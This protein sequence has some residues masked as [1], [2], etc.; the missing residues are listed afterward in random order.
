MFLALAYVLRSLFKRLGFERAELVAVLQVP[1]V[2]NQPAFTLP[3]A[4][5]FA[6]LTELGHFS[7]PGTTFLSSSFCPSKETEETYERS[8]PPPKAPVPSRSSW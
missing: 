7:A 4:N 3:L 5:T 6:A 2:D 1:P 8:V